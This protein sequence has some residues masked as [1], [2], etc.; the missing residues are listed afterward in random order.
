MEYKSA[1]V[2]VCEMFKIIDEQVLHPAA[3]IAVLIA[4][5][6]LEMVEVVGVV[7]LKA[8]SGRK[9]TEKY[10]TPT[11]EG[12]EG[13]GVGVDVD[14]RVESE[15]P[16]EVA[17][18]VTEGMAVGEGLVEVE[19][20]LDE[21][22]REE[23]LGVIEPAK[24]KLGVLE[25]MREKVLIAVGF[26]IGVGF[27]LSVAVDT[28]VTES[29]LVGGADKVPNAEAVASAD[30]VAVAEDEA[31]AELEA[32]LVQVSLEFIVKVARR[33]L[34]LDIIGKAVTLGDEDSVPKAK[35]DCRAVEDG[36]S[37][38]EIDE[39]PDAELVEV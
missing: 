31:V 3:D 28:Y 16:E 26:D 18:D 1:P 27:A 39:E 24:R 38:D 25:A 10:P 22:L 2:D 21:V 5:E 14:V 11:A 37:E 4:I 8:L 35:G 9:A 15:V 33:V 36:V 23:R 34:R 20:L 19:I 6:R 32:L 17:E 13:V 12:G 30:A 7:L 29:V